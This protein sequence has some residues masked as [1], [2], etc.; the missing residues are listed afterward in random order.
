VV[1]LK[2]ECPKAGSVK[3]L[4]LSILHAFDRVL[5]TRHAPRGASRASAGDLTSLVSHLAVA[6]HLGILVLDE[7]QNLSA[8]KSGGREEMLN[9]FQELVNEFKLPV[10]LLGTYKARGVLQLDLRHARR[11]TVTGSENWDPLKKDAEFEFL[12]NQLWR[13][14]WLRDAGPLTEEMRNTIY[15]ETQGVRGFIVDMFLV[16]QLHALWKGVETLTP[17]LFRHVARTEFSAV[18]PMLNALRSKD[19]RRLRHFDDLV[20][21][22]L[23]D[24]IDRLTQL[25]AASPTAS[26]STAS[27][28]SSMLGNACARVQSC[29]GLSATEARQL[30]LSVMD[31]SHKSA[32]ALTVAAITAYADSNHGDGASEPVA[33]Q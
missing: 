9:W 25:I 18:Q 1:W 11:V 28:E 6:H 16:A 26:N 30:V 27:A 33:P 15:E 10:A 23:D 14:L 4:A 22:E 7:M 20:S 31:G 17:D 21:V 5:G 19:P 3:D 24:H 8:K 2:V 12:V 13:Y 32:K 29:I